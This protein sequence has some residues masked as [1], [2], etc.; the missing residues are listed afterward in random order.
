MPFAKSLDGSNPLLVLTVAP[1]TGRNRDVLLI[2]IRQGDANGPLLYA[3]KSDLTKASSRRTLLTNVRGVAGM[4]AMTDTMLMQVL[5][6]YRAWLDHPTKAQPF[7]IILRGKTEHDSQGVVIPVAE[8]ADAAA[9]TTA[10]RT[11]LNDM[12][13]GAPDMLLTWPTNHADKLAVVDVDYHHLPEAPS[14]DYTAALAA[15]VRP[16]PLAW[17][18]SHG[19]GL[20]LVYIAVAPYA[21]NE[22]AACAALAITSIDP[23]AT[24]ELLTHT[25]HP[26]SPRSSR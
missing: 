8:P 6:E 14:E 13:I 10:L 20:H 26:K 15:A 24:I 18:R 3:D 19:G 25:R 2:E 9:V 23:T 4:P 1:G 5:A 21:A 12:A 16:R 22:L 17:W 11:A 7:Q